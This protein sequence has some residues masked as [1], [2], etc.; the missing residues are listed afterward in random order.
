MWGQPYD[1]FTEDNFRQRRNSDESTGVAYNPE[2]L[3]TGGEVAA[4]VAE[5][6]RYWPD[7][8]T[9]KLAAAGK[10]TSEKVVEL[11]PRIKFDAE[12]NEIARSPKLVNPLDIPL[13]KGITVIPLGDI[14]SGKVDLADFVGE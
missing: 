9:Y 5:C 6:P 3:I 13:P 10:L 14:A 4:G 2:S 7:E 8:E 11:G 1:Y 12:G